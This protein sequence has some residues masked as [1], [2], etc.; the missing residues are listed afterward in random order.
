MGGG[1]Q[2]RSIW[3]GSAP[4]VKPLVLNPL[5]PDMKVHIL[6]MVLHT[7]GMQ[8]VR[9]ICLNIKTSYPWWLFPL[10]SSPECLKK[11]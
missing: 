6:L 9:R 2:L 7:F 4:R 5:N 11:Q 8:L 10:S 1:T 3:G